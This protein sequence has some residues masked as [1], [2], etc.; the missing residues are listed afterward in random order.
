MRLLFV[1]LASIYLVF[2]SCLLSL[3]SPQEASPTVGEPK[4]RDLI[5]VDC[6][7]GD[8][9]SIATAEMFMPM[10]KQE[11]LAIDGHDMPLDAWCIRPSDFDAKTKY[12]IGSRYWRRQ[13]SLSR[14]RVVDQ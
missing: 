9:K 1:R 11:P 5:R 2:T 3:A 14:S 6:V 7:S 4:D 12:P 13:L 10:G 8:E